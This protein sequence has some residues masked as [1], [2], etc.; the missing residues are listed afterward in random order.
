MRDE[1]VHQSSINIARLREVTAAA[2]EVFTETPRREAAITYLQQRGIDS[3]ALPEQWPLG[4]APSGWTRLVDKL[5]G[6]F[7][8]QALLDAGVARRSSR[9]TLID[10]FRDRVMFL[11]HDLYGQVAGFIGRDLSGSHTAPKY[12]NTHQNTLF[13]KGSLLYGLHEGRAANPS[14]R[15]PVVVEGPIDVLAITARAG[16]T[17][18]RDL[19]PVAASGTAFTTI[20][21]C[22]VAGVAFEHLAP[23]VLAFDGDAAGRAAAVRA[24]ERLRTVGLD[25]RVAVLPNGTDP[26]DYFTQQNSTLDV[27]RDDHAL[28]LLTVQVQYAIARQGDH[29][30]WIEG[31]LAAARAIA[32]YLGTY[33]VSHAAAQIGWI[34]NVLDLDAATFTFE[35]AD[36]YRRAD[37]CPP[38]QHGPPD[39][40]RGA[41]SRRSVDAGD[42]VAGRTNATATPTLG[43]SVNRGRS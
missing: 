25:V 22:H 28:P 30:Q 29:I 16:V 3:A 8:D 32:T 6:Q 34:S 15:Q 43:V 35:L 40:T 21:A 39:L 26:A 9:G 5:R 17:G 2:A 7:P 36:A 38:A 1:A 33:P 37:A 23:V 19:L 20:H 41:V 42:G 10:T 24:G 18:E 14:A 4:Y 27:L 11:V 12:L 13:D 31:R